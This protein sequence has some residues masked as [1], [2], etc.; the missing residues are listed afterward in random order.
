V[1]LQSK[2]FKGDPTLEACL[3]QDSTPVTA[4]AIGPLVA[5]IQAALQTLDRL[6]I[7]AAELSSA[8]YGPST[9]GAVL[10]YTRE[11]NFVN[12]AYQTQADAI[13]GE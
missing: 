3:L 10:S 8:R 6:A 12:P 9:A 5:K 2:H 13:V 11:R 7:E 1:A 4:S